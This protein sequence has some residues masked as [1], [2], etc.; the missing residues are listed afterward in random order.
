MQEIEKV[1]QRFHVYTRKW[2]REES[3]GGE[4]ESREEEGKRHKLQLRV[5]GGEREREREGDKQP[6]PLY[7]FLIDIFHM[8][9]LWLSLYLSPSFLLPLFTLFFLSP[10]SLFLQLFTLWSS[11]LL[12]IGI[13]DMHRI[14]A[15]RNRCYWIFIVRQ[16]ALPSPSL[17]SLVYSPSPSHP[18]LVICKSL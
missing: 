6:R 18:S 8:R 4:V 13:Y 7:T 11:F 16:A 17:F 3:Q 1:P 5:R 10:S 12:P 9:F 2:E 15:N 14:T